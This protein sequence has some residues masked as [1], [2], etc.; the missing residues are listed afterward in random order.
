MFSWTDLLFFYPLFDYSW[1]IEL[2]F[3]LYKLLLFLW[4][5]IHQWLLFESLVIIFVSLIVDLFVRIDHINV[6]L[7]WNLSSGVITICLGRIKT[8]RMDLLPPQVCGRSW[9]GFWLGVQ[10]FL[11]QLIVFLDLKSPSSYLFKPH[12]VD[13]WLVCIIFIKSS[14]TEQNNCPRVWLQ[15]PSGPYP[16]QIY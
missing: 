10:N 8:G 6:N 5:M 12:F 15:T 2:Q 3:N 16:N 14:F 1:F 11:L 4:F 13:C 7:S 9:Q